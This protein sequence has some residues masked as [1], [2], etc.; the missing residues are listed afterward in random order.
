MNELSQEPKLL[1]HEAD[2]IKELDNLLPRWWVWLFNLS[3]VYAMIYMIYYHV[4]GAGDLQA[5]EFHFCI[6]RI[7]RRPRDRADDHTFFAG[8]LVQQTGFAG[9]RFADDGKLDTVI[10]FFDFLS[11][12]GCHERIQQVACACAVYRRDGV[13]VA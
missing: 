8:Q 3:I 6:N 1:E 2:G 4:T 13:G 10:F 11:W 5:A 12:E 7:T 9:V